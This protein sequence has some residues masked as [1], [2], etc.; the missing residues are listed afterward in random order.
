MNYLTDLFCSDKHSD[1]IK[2]FGIAIDLTFEQFISVKEDYNEESITSIQ[3]TLYQ[4]ILR[5]SATSKQLISDTIW[6]GK[7]C[8]DLSSLSAITRAN[9]E[10]VLTLLSFG[11]NTEKREI[12]KLRFHLWRISGLKDTKQ[13]TEASADVIA[14][15]DSRIEKEKEKIKSLK[16]DYSIYQS[17]VD[18]L[19][20]KK[21][22]QLSEIN[23]KIMQTNWASIE[24]KILKGAMLL[25]TASSHPTVIGLKNFQT[26]YSSIN[27]TKDEIY[28]ITK[29]GIVNLCLSYFIIHNIYN[30]PVSEVF[31]KFCLETVI[32]GE[33][34]NSVDNS[35]PS[36]MKG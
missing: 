27:Q 30:T 17:L 36:E 7:D 9:Y 2:L 34:L 25:L 32:S 13:S 26:R 5:K 1:Q 3:F 35:T 11:I 22:W 21:Q 16:I 6:M 33:L 28:I 29:F 4:E 19:I 31:Y 20:K 18:R 23:G 10:F 12:E 8:I 24:F 14:Q 15:I